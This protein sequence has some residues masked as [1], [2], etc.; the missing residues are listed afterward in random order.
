MS[1]P[2]I[3]ASA[4]ARIAH[5]RFSTVENAGTMIRSARIWSSSAVINGIGFGER[6]AFGSR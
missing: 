3:V 4:R 6:R 2:K 5:A 1:W